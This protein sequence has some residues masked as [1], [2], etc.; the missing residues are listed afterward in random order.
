MVKLAD[1]QDLKQNVIVITGGSSGLGKAIAYEAASQGAVIVV[2]A[3]R[4]ASCKSC[5]I[6]AKR[7]Q[8]TRLCLP[9]GCQQSRND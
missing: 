9:I 7:Y 6:N 3:R 1:L 2:L 8:A 5:A 4:Q